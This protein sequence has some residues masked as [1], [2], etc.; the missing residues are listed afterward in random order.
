MFDT[1]FT[2]FSGN[3][4]DNEVY[5]AYSSVERIMS[6]IYDEEIGHTR[7]RRNEDLLSHSLQDQSS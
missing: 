4:P 6:D 7:N 2:T 3:I 5:A 1:C